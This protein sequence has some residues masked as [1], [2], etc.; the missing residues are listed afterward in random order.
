MAAKAAGDLSAGFY[1][2]NYLEPVGACLPRV[3]RRAAPRV[4]QDGVWPARGEHFAGEQQH[5]QAVYRARP[6][7]QLG[8]L[9]YCEVPAKVCSRSFCRACPAACTIPARFGPGSTSGVLDSSSASPRPRRC[10]AEDAEPA[11]KR[12]PR[13]RSTTGSEKADRPLPS[14]ASCLCPVGAPSARVLCLTCFSH[15]CPVF[16]SLRGLSQKVQ[17]L[18]FV[19][20]SPTR[21]G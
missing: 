21:R 9:P 19:H 14:S 5:G 12:A 17:A 15:R 7:Q 2:S 20:R 8:A 6:R 10:R 3:P 18:V 13:V 4:A 16:R 11:K 1:G